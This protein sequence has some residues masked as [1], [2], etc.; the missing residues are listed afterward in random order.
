MYSTL[1]IELAFSFPLFRNELNLVTH[2]QRIQQEPKRQCLYRGEDCLA[3]APQLNDEVPISANVW[4]QCPLHLIRTEAGSNSVSSPQKPPTMVCSWEHVGNTQTVGRFTGY[5]VSPDQE[6][7]KVRMNRYL[8]DCP[9][10]QEIGRHDNKHNLT[11]E[12]TNGETWWKENATC[13]LVDSSVLKFTS[14]FLF[15]TIVIQDVGVG[16]PGIQQPPTLALSLFG[17]S[18]L[19]PKLKEIILFKNRPSMQ[20]I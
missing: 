5:L 12:G 9:R 16:G 3:S 4:V 14:L 20:N 6:S 8:W 10:L 18:K 17:K 15:Y 7:H 11:Q 19:V 13:A 2:F 1:G